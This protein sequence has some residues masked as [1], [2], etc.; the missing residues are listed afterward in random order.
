[1]RYVRRQMPIR[2]KPL[3]NKEQ[4]IETQERR[5]NLTSIKHDMFDSIMTV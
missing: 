3:L 1:M 4:K 5:E 2:I